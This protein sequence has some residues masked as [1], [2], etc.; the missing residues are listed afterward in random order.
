VLVVSQAE[1]SENE[2]R[3]PNRAHPIQ[4]ANQYNQH[5]R[6][7]V[8][9][10]AKFVRGEFRESDYESDYECRIQ[11]IWRPND[12]ESEE[13]VYKP[14]RPGFKT[15]VKKVEGSRHL[16]PVKSVA[17]PVEAFELKPG[18]P[19]EM[20]FAPSPDVHRS[21]SF[22]ES[23]CNESV[24]RTTHFLSSD[25]RGHGHGTLERN[26]EAK[27]L[28]RVDEM[29]KRFEQKSLCPAESGSVQ[30]AVSSQLT[31]GIEIDRAIVIVIIYTLWHYNGQWTIH[32]KSALCIMIRII[33]C[34]IYFIKMCIY[35]IRQK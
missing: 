30:Q 14:V 9:S 8:R 25:G 4:W 10:P 23:E 28:Q 2:R 31:Q 35:C 33:I 34:I 15:P 20:G 1:F 16:Q 18:S 19:P 29:R 6:A 22:V 21:V 5:C 13:P 26:A 12:S 17:A 32:N 24:Q 27:R 7:Q 11:P 3:Q